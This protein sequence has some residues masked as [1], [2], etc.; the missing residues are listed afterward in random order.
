MTENVENLLLEHMKPFQAALERI[1]RKQDELVGRIA[2][3]EGGLASMMQH[4]GNL[5]AADAAQ[6]L[7]IDNIS[8][9][10]D[11]IERRLELSH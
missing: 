11:R 9:R 8:R 7:A 4:L 3:L 2:N 6:Q 5:A 1:E 10:L